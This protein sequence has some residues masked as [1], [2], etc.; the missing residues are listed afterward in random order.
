MATT[1][2]SLAEKAYQYLSEQIAVGRLPAGTRLSDVALARQIGISRT[3]VREAIMLLVAQGLVEQ[4]AG[5]GPQVKALDR[6]ELE[7]VFELRDVLESGNAAVAASRITD[8]ELQEL[9]GLQARYLELIRDFRDRR[10]RNPRAAGSEE[11]GV[12]DLSFHLKILRAARNQRILKLVG[13]LRILTHI[14]RRRVELPAVSPLRRLA[15]NYL[16][17]GRVLRALRQRDPEAARR[18]MHAHLDWA[19]RFHLAAYDWDRDAG[20]A[21]NADVPDYMLQVLTRLEHGAKAPA[22]VAGGRRPWRR[23]PTRQRRSS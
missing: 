8:A 1:H 13:D 17:H 7:E 4:P 21:P 18:A 6:R 23:T 11:V 15:L 5:A 9:A 19:K 12:L 16:G 20:R 3:P 14:L 2:H 10:R 22:P